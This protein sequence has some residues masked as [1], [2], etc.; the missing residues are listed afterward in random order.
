VPSSNCGRGLVVEGKKGKVK[1]QT[2]YLSDL[3]SC[4]Q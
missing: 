3:S 4:L 2:W 1:R